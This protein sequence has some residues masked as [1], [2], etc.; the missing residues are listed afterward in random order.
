MVTS[1]DDC[2]KSYQNELPKGS[3]I[4]NTMEATPSE[5]GGL[6]LHQT[7][8]EPMFVSSKATGESVSSFHKRVID[9]MIKIMAETDRPAIYAIA[10]AL[11]TTDA[12]AACIS[13]VTTAVYIASATGISI[14]ASI[15][16]IARAND[17]SQ[18][19]L[20]DLW[21]AVAL[22]MYAL[23]GE[24]VP[25]PDLESLHSDGPQ[26]KMTLNAIVGAR[27]KLAQHLAEFS[28]TAPADAEAT[29]VPLPLHTPTIDEATHGE[30]AA[31]EHLSFKA[32]SAV[33][34]QAVSLIERDMPMLP[35]ELGMPSETVIGTDY[36]A[37]KLEAVLYSSAAE[38]IFTAATARPPG[39]DAPIDKILTDGDITVSSP[40]ADVIA[41]AAAA[42]PPGFG[43][44]IGKPLPSHSTAATVV[45]TAATARPPGSC[46]LVEEPFSGQVMAMLATM[47]GAGGSTGGA[48][49]DESDDS[50]EA[51]L[52]CLE[53][54]DDLPIAHLMQ[55]KP[56]T[57]STSEYVAYLT[58]IAGYEADALVLSKEE[59]TDKYPNYDV[60]DEDLGPPDDFEIVILLTGADITDDPASV[61]LLVPETMGPA[62]YVRA[63]ME[64][65]V[66]TRAALLAAINA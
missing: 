6:R 60:R 64:M 29:I 59:M 58:A 26:A 10:G 35:H 45:S 41:A 30:L 31:F 54:H 28:E 62:E 20:V 5:S 9:H 37:G 39:F 65:D 3:N 12:E 38:V 56:D 52:E 23:R 47:G 42:R 57:V 61:R 36:S 40:A 27:T 19:S 18:R 63:Y 17:V 53:A 55:L 48:A 14:D 25:E 1:D 13:F 44:L 50:S 43:E 66:E 24:I 22:Q 21:D 15:D 16:L 7:I 33:E 49:D 46:K 51:A 32:P 2:H 4:L 8:E 34:K 11:S